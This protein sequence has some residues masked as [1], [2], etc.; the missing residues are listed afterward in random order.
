MP[1]TSMYDIESPLRSM[2]TMSKSNTGLLIF[3]IT[4]G[5][6]MAIYIPLRVIPQYNNDDS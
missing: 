6:F 3:L 2:S 4:M 1:R 5:L